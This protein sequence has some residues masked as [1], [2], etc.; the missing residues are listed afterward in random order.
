[1]E[2]SVARH[3]YLFPPSLTETTRLN[4]VTWLSLFLLPY[5]IF[6]VLIPL[7]SLSDHRIQI[8]GL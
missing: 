8:N 3:I 1:M 2:F 5:V 7:F 6:R 4:S